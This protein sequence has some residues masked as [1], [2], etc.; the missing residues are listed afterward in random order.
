MSH[1]KASI[2]GLGDFSDDQTTAGGKHANSF[3]PFGF[4]FASARHGQE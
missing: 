4:Y 1:P 2:M 3:N